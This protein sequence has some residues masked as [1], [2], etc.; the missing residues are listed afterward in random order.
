MYVRYVQQMLISR[1][2]ILP[3]IITHLLRDFQSQTALLTTSHGSTVLSTNL[4]ILQNVFL[5][6]IHA[7]IDEGLLD[8]SRLAEVLL[9]CPAACAH[10][11]A[12]VLAARVTACEGLALL[13]RFLLLMVMPCGVADEIS[14]N[15]RYRECLYAAEKRVMRTVAVFDCGSPHV[16]SAFMD[17][18]DQISTLLA[19]TATRVRTLL[20]SSTQPSLVPAGCQG[21]LGKLTEVIPAI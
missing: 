2:P 16:H 13:L 12:V 3:Y 10:T 9:T 14:W 20:P 8:V 17:A 15:A 21:A 7:A 1:T 4:E 6:F 19:P 5:C 18:L 11:A